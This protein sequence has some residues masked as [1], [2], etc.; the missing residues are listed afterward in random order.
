MKTINENTLL[1]T[2][3]RSEFIEII[4]SIARV[5]PY[6]NII[7]K[8][9]EKGGMRICQVND[10]KNVLVRLYLNTHWF[11]YFRCDKPEITISINMIDFVKKLDKFK[12]L[13]TI[14]LYIKA[15]NKDILYI[16]SEDDEAEAKYLF[17]QIE[18]DKDEII[19]PEQVHLDNKITIST[20]EFYKICNYFD[21][22]LVSIVA[23]SN[24]ISFSMSDDNGIKTT[25]NYQDT[26]KPSDESNSTIVSENTFLDLSVLKY[27]GGKYKILYDTIDVFSKG[28]Y[29]LVLGM[30]LISDNTSDIQP[31]AKGRLCV[32]FSPIETNDF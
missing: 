11:T 12:K 7:F 20:H 10:T 28:N 15:V 14:N 17:D 4:K 22:N 18:M 3:N 30:N 24:N 16:G 13:N 5:I 25:I 32:F 19:I 1:L 23:T 9:N 27:F 8:S 26:N 31:L 6:C 21:T 2:T 29:P